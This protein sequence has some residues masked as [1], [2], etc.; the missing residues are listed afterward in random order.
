M[1]TKKKVWETKNCYCYICD[2][3]IPKR[4]TYLFV[5]EANAFLCKSCWN[6]KNDKGQK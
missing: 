2:A 5:E 6:L 3:K 1:E 4:V